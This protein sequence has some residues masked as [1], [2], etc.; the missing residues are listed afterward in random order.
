MSINAAIKEL[1][2][3]DV[4]EQL[5]YRKLAKKHSVS[6][7][8]LA[9][10]AQGIHA[11]VQ[12]SGLN[13]R[14]LHPRDEAELVKYIRGL[15]KRHLMPT[16]Q[17]IINFTT[18]LCAWEPSDS[19]VTR[20]LHRNKEMLI[21]AWTTP[22]ESSRHRADSG[23][24]YS[25]YFELLHQKVAEYDLQPENTYNMDEKGFMIGV[26]SRSKR[27]FDKLLFSQR[28]FKQSLHDGNRE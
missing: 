20:F 24:K 27:V 23:A 7:V 16:R 2:S 1:E 15:T 8:T 11:S 9:E 17:M 21:T 10:R 22:M 4:G 6:R 28:Q 14:L 5:S 25:K 13:K 26:S 18:P 3:T 12:D 19:W